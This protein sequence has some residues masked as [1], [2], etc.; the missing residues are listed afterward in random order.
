M[1]KLVSMNLIAVMVLAAIVS[2]APQQ[3]V[4]AQ[5]AGL[6][7]SIINRMERNRRDL[8]SLRAAIRMEKQN[9]QFNETD[10]YTGTV[11]YQPAGQNASVRVDWRSPQQETLAVYDGR[12]TLFRPRLNLA[13]QGSANSERNRVSNVLGFGMSITR[14]QLASRFQPMQYIG[15]E[16][17]NGVAT[18]HIL[19]E[20]RGN[21]SYRYAEVWVDGSGMPVQTRIVER[22]YDTTTVTLSNVQRNA[23]VSEGD[24]RLQLGDGVRIVR[25]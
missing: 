15:E 13:Y 17:V 7:S 24:F 12:Y 9:S 25:S 22:N 6:V 23:P 20:P 5:G 10:R 14:Q 2:V 16:N 11:I 1:R 4:N 3:E 18:S 21:A 8:R 19:L